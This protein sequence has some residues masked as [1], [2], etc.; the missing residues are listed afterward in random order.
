M[1]SEM[2]I[3]MEGLAIWTQMDIAMERLAIWTQMDITMEGLAIWTHYMD[4][5]V[6]ELAVYA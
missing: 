4:I 3:A 5:A 2:G 1:H 6:D